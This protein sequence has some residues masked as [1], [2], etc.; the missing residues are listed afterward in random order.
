MSEIKKWF[1]I[2]FES[3]VVFVTFYLIWWIYWYIHRSPNLTA[4]DTINQIV[5]LSQ[6]EPEFLFPSVVNQ[7]HFDNTTSPCD[8]FYV[9]NNGAYNYP[10]GKIFEMTSVYNARMLDVIDNMI[11][12][13]DNTLCFGIKCEPIIKAYEICLNSDASDVNSLINKAI[14]DYESSTQFLT[15]YGKIGYL[16]KHGLLSPVFIQL[17]HS[18]NTYHVH[19]S[20][21]YEFD[22][23]KFDEF[24]F[25]AFLE[26]AHEFNRMHKARIITW[27]DFKE[28]I[29]TH[30]VSG[31][32]ELFSVAFGKTFHRK[33]K[34]GIEHI[35]FF[36]RISTLLSHDTIGNPYLR[37]VIDKYLKSYIRYSFGDQIFKSGGRKSCLELIK[38]FYPA[39]LCKLS[40]YLEHRD[41][42]DNYHQVALKVLKTV[43]ETY[44]YLYFNQTNDF[45][46][47]DDNIQ[48]GRCSSLF[49]HVGSTE[50]MIKIE[51]KSV[52]DYTNIFELINNNFMRDSHWRDMYN[53]VEMHYSIPSRIDGERDP[54]SWF[55]VVNAWMDGYS[56]KIVFPPGILRAPMFSPHYDLPSQYGMLGMVIA[57]EITHS[58]AHRFDFRCIYTRFGNNEFKSGENIADSVG[59]RVAFHSMINAF[60]PATPES[61]DFCNFFRSYASLWAYAPNGGGGGGPTDPHEKPQVRVN[62]V[63]QFLDQDMLKAY[64]FCFRCKK[65]FN[66]CNIVKLL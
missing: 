52:D 6:D 2:A 34:L 63:L 29:G 11:T 60:K 30:A 19:P 62:T 36:A 55:T 50:M 54:L 33:D 25:F 49:S 5:D 9:N 61:K 41:E 56:N 27:S 53:P 51:Q 3:L 16:I 7:A 15:L 10:V 40:L 18:S 28:I 24:D 64:N 44:N 66:E 59:L 12:T 17:D 14:A 47:S 45:L 39:S 57:H 21:I 20:G 31:W 46:S 38:H 65:K 26:S 58:Q 22:M 8:N 32:E 1:K 37:D 13:G 4:I 23:P 48:F 35:N 43:R 42:N